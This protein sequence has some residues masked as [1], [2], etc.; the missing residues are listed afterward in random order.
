MKIKGLTPMLIIILV[1]M[2]FTGK[3]YILAPYLANFMQIVEHMF[4]DSNAIGWSILIL[5]FIVRIVL[6]PMQ[7]HQSRNMTIQQEKMRLLQPQLNRVQEA[8]KAAKTPEEQMRASQAM[9]HIYRENNVSLLGGMNF[10]TLIIQWPIFS[11]LYAAINPHIIHGWSHMDWAVTQATSI[12]DAN[13]FG[14]QLAQSSLWLAIATGLIYLAQS[15]LSMLGIPEE[16]KKQMKSMMFMM[17]IMMF[18]MTYFTNAGI[19]LY[20]FGGA[21]I[22]VIQTLLINLWRPR[23]RQHVKNTFTVK[24]VVE[25]ALAGKIQAPQ[26]DKNSSFMER[27]AAA[28]EA[29]TKQQDQQADK[30]ASQE[31]PAQQSEINLEKK[32]TN[33]ERNEQR[34]QQNQND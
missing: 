5:T 33:R 30:S 12:K 3:I 18:M 6:L 13:F 23:L 14:I 29:A 17:P 28:Q 34:R 16:Q 24:D 8:Q 32:L 31:T 1:I 15:Y 25:D 19:G 7:L 26:V 21:V 4:N 9:M 20:F 11:G 27:M 22:M 2:F 10:T